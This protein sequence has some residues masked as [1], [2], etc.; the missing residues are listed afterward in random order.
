ML[1]IFKVLFTD[2][3]IV[4]LLAGLRTF[5]QHLRFYKKTNTAQAT[6]LS[7]QTYI[8]GKGLSKYKYSVIRI[9]Y[10]IDSIKLEAE[11]EYFGSCDWAQEGDVVDIV[12]G[13]QHLKDPEIMGRNQR[14]GF[15]RIIDMVILTILV[16]LLVQ[17]ITF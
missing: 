14:N 13:D 2:L 6:I 16:I 3:L 1:Q 17:L 11:L 12:Y 10:P 9:E 4:A 7:K 8:E 15:V 5:L